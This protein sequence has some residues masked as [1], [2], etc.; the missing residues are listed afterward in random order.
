ML[1]RAWRKMESRDRRIT[2][3]VVCGL[4]AN[5]A[6]IGAGVVTDIRAED[7]R[8]DLEAA[9][10]ILAAELEEV[11]RENPEASIP[12]PEETLEGAGEDPILVGKPGPPGPVGPPG[13]DGEPGPPGEPGVV[14][15]PGPP[16]PVGPQG[17]PGV[18]GP[19][20]PQGSQGEPGPQGPEGSPGP[21]CPVGYVVDTIEVGVLLDIVTILV[22][23]AG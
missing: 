9:V 3:I 16:G 5:F 23:V 17:E 14:G 21:M 19:P 2:T 6:L 11:R 13:R 20:G 4:A 12:T 1:W 8:Q 7:K 10:G 18:I 22:C 15:E